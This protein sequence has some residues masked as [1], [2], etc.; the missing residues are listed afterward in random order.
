MNPLEIKVISLF[1]PTLDSRQSA[2][3]LA[4]IIKDELIDNLR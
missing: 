3:H 1:P 4:K 2:T